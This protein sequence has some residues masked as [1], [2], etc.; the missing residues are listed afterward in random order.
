MRIALR[1]A[2][3]LPVLAVLC[4]AAQDLERV[5]VVINDRSPRSR[6]IG[7]YYARKRAIPPAQVLRLKTSTSEEISREEYDRELAAPI[8]AFL[9][10][11]GWIDRI[12]YIVTTHDVPLKIRGKVDRTGDAAAVDSELATLYQQLRGLNVPVHGFIDNPYYRQ[13]GPFNHPQNALY[14]VTRLTG[15]TFEDVK[16]MIDK[17]LVAR[18]RG[19]VVLD[20]KGFALGDGNYWLKLAAG[21]APR[22]RVVIDESDN[23]LTDIADVIAY[24]SWGSNDPSRKSRFARMGWLPGAIATEYVSTDGRTFMEPPPNWEIGPWG[25][26][27]RYFAGSPQSLTADFIREGATGASGHVYEPFLQYTPRPN[28]LVQA[29][30]REGRNL[31]ESF[32]A[33]MPVLSWMNV[34]VGDPLCRLAPE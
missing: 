29:Y 24:A 32:Y 27:L 22:N 31:A 6:A 30:V 10:G 18:N 33:A 26:R 9:R 19:K 4:P 2:A 8:A 1:L 5:L 13:K 23:I 21:Q 28:V 34:I 11:K 25:N 17:S 20:L 7:E 14:M 3:L 12:H 15:Y 16:R